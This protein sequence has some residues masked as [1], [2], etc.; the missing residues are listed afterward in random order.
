[1]QNGANQLSSSKSIMI[2]L[3]KIDGVNDQFDF[4][5]I[6]IRKQGPKDKCS[7]NVGVFNV[8]ERLVEDRQK[9]MKVL[10]I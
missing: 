3:L 5:L 4:V 9:E 7:V 6:H 2:C 10:I 1:M 8:A